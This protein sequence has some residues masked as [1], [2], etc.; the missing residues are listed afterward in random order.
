MGSVATEQ[1]ATVWAATWVPSR[2]PV[3][4][5]GADGYA[6]AWVDL[7]SGERVQVLVDGG[8]PDPGATGRIEPRSFGDASVDVFVEGARS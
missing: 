6:V 4:G 5:F 3:D 2:S 8:S 1:R 7:D